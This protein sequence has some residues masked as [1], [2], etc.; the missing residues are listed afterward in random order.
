MPSLAFKNVVM[1]PDPESIPSWA[2]SD[3]PINLEI[4]QVNDQGK[5]LNTVYEGNISLSNK[6]GF[7]Q[8]YM[9]LELQSLETRSHS[10]NQLAPIV[11]EDD[12]PKLIITV[13]F[14]P[15]FQFY[16]RVLEN[17]KVARVEVFFCSLFYN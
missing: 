13:N 12:I 14:T 4:F 17:V 16:K 5:Q 7:H 9:E 10:S 2:D 1:P 8:Y 3:V 6:I 11:E 15:H